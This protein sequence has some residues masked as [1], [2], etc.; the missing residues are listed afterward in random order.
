[1]LAFLIDNIYMEFSGQIFQQTVGIPMGTN[2]AS[3]FFAA[4][5]L[6]GYKAEFIQGVL[7]TGMNTLLRKSTSYRYIDDVLFLSNSSI[8]EFID[9]I[10]PRDCEM[11]DTT[12]STICLIPRL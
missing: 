5:F 11:K 1:M 10:S 7:I 9:F 12:E 4:L 6:Y 8:S 2:Y 3:P